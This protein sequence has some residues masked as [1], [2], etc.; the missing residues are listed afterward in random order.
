MI[1]IEAIANVA[2]GLGAIPLMGYP[3]PPFRLWMIKWSLRILDTLTRHLC[4]M[5]SI[6]IHDPLAPPLSDA[7]TET[8]TTTCYMCACRCGIRVHLR[9]GEIRYIDGNPDH[10]LN[11]GVICAKGSSGIMKQYSPA[12]LTKP[13]R[14]KPGTERGAGDFE[15]ISWEETFRCWPSGWRRFAPPIRRNSRC[16]PGATRCRR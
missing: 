10:P 3:S 4:P 5:P 7:T 16:S 11:G 8:R 15:E 9:N 14:R 13:L 6:P 2:F 12:R 1:G